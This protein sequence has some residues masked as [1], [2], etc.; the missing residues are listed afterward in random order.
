MQDGDQSTA[1]GFGF[2]C[3]H[4]NEFIGRVNFSPVQPFDLSTAQTS[5]GTNREEWDQLGPC[6]SEELCDLPRGKDFDV[7]ASSRL[8]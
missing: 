3:L 5:K 6:V 2:V 8:E 1:G 7:T 4:F